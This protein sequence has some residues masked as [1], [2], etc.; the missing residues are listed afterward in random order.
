[1]VVPEDFIT[2]VKADKKAFAN[3]RL[4]KKTDLY[5]IGMKLQTA[6]KVETRERRF[7][8]LLEKVHK[9]EPL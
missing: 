9:G 1:M 8:S 2:A 7:N 6:K 3:Y 5:I 4:L